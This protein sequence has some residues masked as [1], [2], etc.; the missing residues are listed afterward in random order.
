MA[1]RT[2]WSDF[3]SHL[4]RADLHA[5]SADYTHRFENT[6][7]AENGN[8]AYLL[9]RRVEALGMSSVTSSLTS[10]KRI[11]RAHIYVQFFADVRFAIRLQ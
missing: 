5:D 2:D 10:T 3:L 7:G 4:S 8:R 6:T 11:S 9:V 1:R